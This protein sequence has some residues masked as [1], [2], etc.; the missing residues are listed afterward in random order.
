MLFHRAILLVTLRMGRFKGVADEFHHVSFR[1]LYV[2]VKKLKVA[3]SRGGE[4]T[5]LRGL[6]PPPLSGGSRGPHSRPPLRT[7]QRRY[8]NP[9]SQLGETKKKN[10]KQLRTNTAIACSPSFEPINASKCAWHFACTRD[11]RFVARCFRLKHMLLFL[12]RIRLICWFKRS[13]QICDSRSEFMP[14]DI[15]ILILNEREKKKGKTLI[16]RN[17]PD[18]IAYIPDPSPLLVRFLR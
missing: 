9:N 4:R 2:I 12:F 3:D 16:Y 11:L 5:P 1:L 7:L 15:K 13:K 14:T 8:M 10:K 6:L 17:E 18:N